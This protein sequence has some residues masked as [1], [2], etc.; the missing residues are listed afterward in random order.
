M[1]VSELSIQDLL[2]VD[3][4]AVMIGSLLVIFWGIWQIIEKAFGSTTWI[5]NLH[6]KRE[7]KRQEERK[8][9]LKPLVEALEEI[10]VIDTTQNQK[11]DNLL[12]SSNDTLR[13]ELLRMY[14]NY[15]PYKKIPQ[16]A[17]EAAVKLHDDYV[18]QDGNTFVQD[19]WVQMSTWEVVPGEE[20][21]KIE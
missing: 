11:L 13:I 17:K 5:K 14:F 12:Q 4:V 6:K 2:K 1:E 15:R 7:A 18:K 16:W 8:E 20:D 10:K 19:L 9:A 21:L 3:N